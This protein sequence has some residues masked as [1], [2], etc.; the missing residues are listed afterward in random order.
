MEAPS[1]A[2]SLMREKIENISTSITEPVSLSELK[3]HLRVTSNSE[4]AYLLTLITQARE[5][6]ETYANAVIAQQSFRLTLDQFVGQIYLPYTPV[7]SIDSFTYVDTAGA[8]QTLTSSDYHFSNTA[9]DPVLIPPYSE[10]WPNA[11]D[12]YEKVVIEFTAGFATAPEYA[13]AA[14]MMIAGDLWMNREDS[15]PVKLEAVNWQ[16]SALLAPIR[17]VKM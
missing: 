17:K 6:A 12:G 8:T 13:K 9:Y 14:I 11:Q 16:A 2:L 4:D 3:T 7:I 1:G 5:M 15:A 10:S